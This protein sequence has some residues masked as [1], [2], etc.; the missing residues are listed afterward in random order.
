MVSFNPSLILIE[1]DQKS[2]GNLK[3]N[4]IDENSEF[5]VVNMGNLSHQ[6]RINPKT[7]Y[8]NKGFSPPYMSYVDDGLNE[9]KPGNTSNFDQMTSATHPYSIDLMQMQ[10]GVDPLI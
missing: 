9:I 6:R 10:V 7:G 3:N 5:E 1:V 2:S 4:T 8:R